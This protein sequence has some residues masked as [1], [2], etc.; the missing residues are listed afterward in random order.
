MKGTKKIILKVIKTKFAFFIIIR[1]IKKMKH[2]NNN[3]C[4]KMILLL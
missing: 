1:I 2:N 4:I 3:I